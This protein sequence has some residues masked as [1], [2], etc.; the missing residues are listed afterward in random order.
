MSPFLGSIISSCLPIKLF[1]SIL[2]FVF[3]FNIYYLMISYILPYLWSVLLSITC[4]KVSLTSSLREGGICCSLLHPQCID[5]C[6][7]W[8]RCL[9]SKWPL[10]NINELTEKI[11]YNLNLKFIS[12][13]VSWQNKRNNTISKKAVSP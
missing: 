2:C 8:S 4:S 7:A 10:E 3:I 12:K 6:V 1:I 5:Q 13:C 11:I 9:I